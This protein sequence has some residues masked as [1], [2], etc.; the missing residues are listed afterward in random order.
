VV[1]VGDRVDD[2]SRPVLSVLTVYVIAWLDQNWF[3]DTFGT[4]PDS[5]FFQLLFL[6]VAT[7]VEAAFFAFLAS[8]MLR[9]RRREVALGGLAGK[10]SSM[11]FYAACTGL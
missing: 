5:E 4:G 1:L 6:Y 9:R 8:V 3:I 2:R 10:Y 7:L 11:F